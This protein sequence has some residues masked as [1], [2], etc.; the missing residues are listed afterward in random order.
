MRV[1]IPRPDPT[2]AC[3]R[4]IPGTTVPP[5]LPLHPL[6]SKKAAA[7]SSLSTTCYLSFLLFSNYVLELE[8]IT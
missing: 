2:A 7:S 1:A 8:M 6:S 5:H 3:K 4:L